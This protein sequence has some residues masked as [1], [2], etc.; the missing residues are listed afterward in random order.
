MSWNTGKVSFIETGVIHF[1]E[2]V[3]VLNRKTVLIVLS[4]LAISLGVTTVVYFTSLR[5][6]L[7]ALNKSG[8][9]RLAQAEDRLLGQLEAFRE[10][11][12][13]LSRHPAIVSAAY[14]TSNPSVINELLLRSALL[15][16]ADS[17][18]LLDQFGV[19]VASSNYEEAFS[20]VG[21]DYS[22]RPDVKSA[23]T[24][25]L[26]VYHGIEPA[27][28]TRDFFYTRGVLTNG[29]KP[30]GFLVVKVNAALLEF[31]WR[32]DENVVVFIDNDSVF[33]LANRPGLIL[34]H[35]KPGE[36]TRYPVSA[37]RDFYDYSARQIGP[38]EIRSFQD[39]LDV[40]SEALIA[41]REIPLIDMTARIFMDT[42]EAT[43]PAFLQAALAGAL[44]IISGLFVF[45]VTQRRKRIT[46][47]LV[48]EEAANARLEARVIERTEQL[49]R[50]Q[51][52][53]LQASKLTAL[54]QMSAG[55][56]HELNQPLATIQN[57]AENSKK[58]LDR[59]RQEDAKDNLAKISEQTTR[60]GRII[61][62]LRS[63][64]RK[65][66]EPLEALDIAEVVAEAVNLADARCKK[67]GVS[68]VVHTGQGPFIVRAGQVRLQ[69]VIV[70]LLSNA[71]D[72]MAE[73]PVR[74]IS[75]HIERHAKN[76][77]LTVV[78]TGPGLQDVDRVFE[79][80]YTTKEIGASKGLGLGLSISYGIIG[81]FGGELS[82]RN[83][84]HG[85][86]EFKIVLPAH[87]EESFV[88]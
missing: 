49:K 52:E 9:V 36:E 58:L 79:P 62:N 74:E 21:W 38:Y 20:F 15:S 72:A 84:D 68:V 8:E 56:S 45:S 41:E 24:G 87:K 18:Y 65:E 29:V 34:R 5:A 88:E 54:G 11:S 23:A 28:Q 61:Q 22:R 26:G 3:F 81:S 63:F 64:A 31:N 53:L 77:V 4:Y 51:G 25:R 78:D 66:T 16:G 19:V 76:I 35:E 73:A 37:V 82:A 33:F 50:T 13:F 12:N 27:D 42:K 43:Q 86:A 17:I 47:R 40:P 6:N 83:L 14:K 85:G 55:I 1:A 75:I 70:N 60:M 59:G 69:Q 30:S 39:G 67:A 32:I 10:L 80:F 46:D 2:S 48:V 44:M 71:V 7:S 57:Y